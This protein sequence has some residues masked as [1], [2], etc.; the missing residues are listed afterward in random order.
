LKNRS[1]TSEQVQDL[2]QRLNEYAGQQET[3]ATVEDLEIAVIEGKVE[4]T[5]RLVPQ[6]DMDA[7]KWHSLNQD[8]ERKIQEFLVSNLKPPQR[9]HNS[10]KGS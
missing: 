4:T 6:G 8:I 10:T 7:R 1:L 2:L 5:F 3:P 9:G